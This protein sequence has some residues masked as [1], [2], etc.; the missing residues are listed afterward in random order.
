MK[1]WLRNISR[2]LWKLGAPLRH[3]F[4]RK[5]HA[6]LDRAVT[7]VL[8]NIASLRQ[9]AADHA[10]YVQ[11]LDSRI[12]ALEQ[13][14]DIAQARFRQDLGPTID[15]MVRDLARLQVQMEA[16]QQTISHLRSAG[17]QLSRSSFDDRQAG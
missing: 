14:L 10:R 11:N 12:A 8:Q 7:P 2:G 17:P 13:R 9:S 16:L 5:V 15:G 1:H 6:S 4:A 3:P